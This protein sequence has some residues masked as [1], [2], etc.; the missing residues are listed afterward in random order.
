MLVWNLMNVNTK[1]A[2]IVMKQQIIMFLSSQLYLLSIW[3]VISKLSSQTKIRKFDPQIR[4]I[5]QHIAGFQIS[6]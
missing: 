5:N 4:F 2:E 1:T 6:M 3:Y